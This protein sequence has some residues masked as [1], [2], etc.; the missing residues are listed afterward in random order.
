[1]LSI[2]CVTRG[3]E[4][5]DEWIPYH[6]DFFENNLNKEWE[7]LVVSAKRLDKWKNFHPRLKIKESSAPG[8]GRMIQGYE[9]ALYDFVFS[10]ADDDYI[11]NFNSNYID[12]F[13]QQNVIGVV[14]E[15][16]FS[17]LNEWSERLEDPNLFF[18][19]SSKAKLNAAS[20]DE[21]I[22]TYL[23]PP[24][25]GDNSPYYGIYRRKAHLA[26]MKEYLWF[27]DREYIATDWAITLALLSRGAV[28]KCD[29]FRMIRHMTPMSETLTQKNLTLKLSVN[30]S[31]ILKSMPFLPTLTF[32][33]D[34]LV[35]DKT[36]VWRNLVQWNLIRYSQLEKSG[37]LT[38]EDKFDHFSIIQIFQESTWSQDG[39]DYIFN[40]YDIINE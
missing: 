26:S 23:T 1:M 12:L 24:L 15:V 36:K 34:F 25:P 29:G 5:I 13:T 22:N 31:K 28:L 37:L 30:Q 35:E 33:R 40:I 7:V 16:I 4:K 19:N 20:S 14:P 10:I 21:R 17:T 18:A 2:V 6:L 32:I 39:D 9:E 8:Y 38:N 11:T 27:F 3:D